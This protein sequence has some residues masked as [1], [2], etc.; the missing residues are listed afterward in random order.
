MG[1]ATLTR[2]HENHVVLWK[3]WRVDEPLD[4]YADETFNSTERNSWCCVSA[5]DR[6]ERTICVADAHRDDGKRF[7]V[8]ADEKLTW[9]V[10]SQSGREDRSRQSRDGRK[11]SFFMPHLARVKMIIAKLT[12]HPVLWLPLARVRRPLRKSPHERAGERGGW[13]V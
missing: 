5:V 3:A 9:A 4:K 11:H 7:V 10:A 1:Q 13:A 8:R 12:G 2:T 6:D